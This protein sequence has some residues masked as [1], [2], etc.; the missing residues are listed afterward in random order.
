MQTPQHAEVDCHV[1]LMRCMYPLMMWRTCRVTYL[2]K[3]GNATRLASTLTAAEVPELARI[4][5]GQAKTV[6]ENRVTEPAQPGA[7]TGGQ[8]ITMKPMT[9][10][11]S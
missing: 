8:A 5:S 2:S 3:A 1:H 9:G 6:V 7:L 4:A 11:A 10:A